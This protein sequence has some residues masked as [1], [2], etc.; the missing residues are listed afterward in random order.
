MISSQKPKPLHFQWIVEVLIECQL[1]VSDCRNMFALVSKSTWENISF[2][3]NFDKSDLA[4]LHSVK[5]EIDCIDF[6]D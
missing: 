6:Y 2:E 3:E 5:I 4:S 1:Y